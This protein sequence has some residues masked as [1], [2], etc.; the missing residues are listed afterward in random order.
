[1]GPVHLMGLAIIDALKKYFLIYM[2][3]FSNTQY[4][5]WC[6]INAQ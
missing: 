6:G 3:M 5:A 2:A 1:M 4:N